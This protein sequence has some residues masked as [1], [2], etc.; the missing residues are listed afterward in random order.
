[1]S[2]FDPATF[3][4]ATVATVDEKRPPLPTENP[5]D[6]GGLYTAVIQPLP[7]PKSGIIGKGDRTGQPWVSMVI[8]L[9]IDVPQQLQDA[10][11]LPPQV[12]LTDKAFLDLTPEGH[13]DDAPGKNSSR[14]LYREA[15]GLNS[16]GV[17]FAWR[18]LE[19]R[20]VKVKVKHEMYNN[21]PVERV[22]MVLP[23]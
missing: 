15:T 8:P 6:S 21:A 9:K 12:T 4:D 10:L 3:L 16:P 14:R 17:P 19:G 22:D 2:A 1:M 7:A 11:K 20:V 5:A 23:A 18:M 13:T